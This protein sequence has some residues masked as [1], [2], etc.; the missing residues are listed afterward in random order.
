MVKAQLVHTPLG[1][2]VCEALDN[3]SV[4][5]PGFTLHGYVV[6][7]DHVHFN[8]RIEPGMADP[9]K[10]LGLAIRGF[11]RYTAALA[12]TLEQG[13]RQDAAEPRDGAMA[14]Q[15]AAVPRNGAIARQDAAVRWLIA[16]ISRRL[17]H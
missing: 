8:L 6:M 7:P 3:F 4:I 5:H 11:K 13:A 2:A 10:R 15:D 12:L 1:K 16:Q 9:L 14:R 17:A